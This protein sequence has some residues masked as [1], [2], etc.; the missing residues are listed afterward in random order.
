MPNAPIDLAPAFAQPRLDNVHRLASFNSYSPQRPAPSKEA[1]EQKFRSLSSSVAVQIQRA[2]FMAFGVEPFV[3]GSGTVGGGWRPPIPYDLSL[4]KT[5]TGA[6]TFR[7]VQDGVLANWTLGGAAI[8]PGYALASGTWAPGALPN[9]DSYM[10]YSSEDS[11][12]FVEACDLANYETVTGPYTGLILP[13]NYAWLGPN[14]WWTY[15]DSTHAGINPDYEPYDGTDFVC[16]SASDATVVLSSPCTWADVETASAGVLTLGYGTYDYGEFPYAVAYNSGDGDSDGTKHMRLVRGRYRFSSVAYRRRVTWKEVTRRNNAGTSAVA[17]QGGLIP[18]LTASK[19]STALSG[20]LALPYFDEFG[21]WAP[22]DLQWEQAGYKQHV[23]AYP[24][25]AGAALILFGVDSTNPVS[26]WP[27]ESVVRTFATRARIKVESELSDLSVRLTVQTGYDEEGPT[28]T[29]VD[30]P[31]VDG[32]S[33]EVDFVAEE[34]PSNEYF[35]VL[36]GVQVLLDG[37]PVVVPTRV[38]YKSRRVLLISGFP[39]MD[40][41][42]TFMEPVRYATETKISEWGINATTSNGADYAAGYR[43][44]VSVTGTARLETKME[45]D[46]ATGRPSWTWMGDQPGTVVE[47]SGSFNGLAWMPSQHATISGSPTTDTGVLREK[48]TSVPVT[49]KFTEPLD[50]NCPSTGW[51]G[52]ST[53]LKGEVLS[54]VSKSEIIEAGAA[55]VWHDTICSER[56]A[57]VFLED[58]AGFRIP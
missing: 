17:Y 33:G 15:S 46:A 13:T 38:T 26:D 39:S 23:W 57:A 32:W 4:Y 49:A 55:G 35:N 30:S 9:V 24:D 56:G 40:G 45:Y 37:E 53:L 58:T 1:T 5:R 34:E 11:I 2:A 19:V 36:T 54:S 7:R 44:E 10:E 29:T 8:H 25:E 31:V 50:A 51:T 16:L 28:Y 14:S 20:A 21:A 43:Y 52:G 41:T 47:A 12:D 6:G 18:Q 27:W 22:D 3:Q 42:S 48:L